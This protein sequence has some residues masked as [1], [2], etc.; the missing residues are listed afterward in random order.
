MAA[1]RPRQEDFVDVEEVLSRPWANELTAS[2]IS[3]AERVCASTGFDM[4]FGAA[5]QNNRHALT[6]CLLEDYPLSE[7]ALV[8]GL[9]MAARV[10]NKDVTARILAIREARSSARL[11]A[12]WS[13]A[14]GHG[15]NDIAALIAEFLPT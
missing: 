13:I 12:P 9:C 7:R 8:L 3:S 10:G 11:A 4:I 5:I 14:I 2:D 15:H 6:E 1:K